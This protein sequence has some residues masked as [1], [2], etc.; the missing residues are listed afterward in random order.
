MTKHSNLHEVEV[1]TPETSNETSEPGVSETSETSVS[2]YPWSRRAEQP[3]SV[4]VS[5][6]KQPRTLLL[7]VTDAET[8]ELIYGPSDVHIEVVAV[9][10]L[11]RS[12]AAALLADDGT[13]HRVTI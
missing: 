9:S 2:V 3:V 6:P 12:F 11:S 10:T 7:R 1:F 13:L 5:K 8:G 4:K